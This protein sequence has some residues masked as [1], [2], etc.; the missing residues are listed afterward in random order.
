MSFANPEA[1]L[2][3]FSVSAG[4][5]T[6]S[7]QDVHYSPPAPEAGELV[8][9]RVRVSNNS[10]ERREGEV[11]LMRGD[12]IVA[13]QRLEAGG[14][15]RQAVDLEWRAEPLHGRRLALR[16]IDLSEMQTASKTSSGRDTLAL[17]GFYVAA[18]GGAARRLE[19]LTL[20]V[21]NEA[22]AGIRLA[23]MS[24]SGCG[25]SVDL[26]VTPLVT[27][28]GHLLVEALAPEGGLRDLGPMLLTAGAAFP[29][30]GGTLAS[31]ARLEEGHTYLV[32]SRGQ[33]ALVRVKRV[34]SAIAPRLAAVLGGGVAADGSDKSGR[35]PTLPGKTGGG[36]GL[37]DDLRDQE[38]AGRLLDSNLITVE[39]EVFR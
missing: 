17:R 28:D 6:L 20:Q 21:R 32:E 13:R 9:F 18:R 5:L 11:L 35:G 33:Q 31:R 36:S 16:L 1:E 37:L 19:R 15:R 2:G 25:G 3:S 14:K 26:E 8:R 22:C 29:A 38:R 23:A 27:S 12:A 10:A 24:S 39:L 30:A 34:R 4:D 7:A